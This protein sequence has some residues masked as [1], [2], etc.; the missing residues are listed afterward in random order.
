MIVRSLDDIQGTDRD[1]DTPN[2]VSKRLLLAKDGTAFS[3]HDTVIRAGTETYMWYAHHVE[4]V[5]CVGGEGE[6]ET[7]NDG[8]VYKI[9]DGAMYTLDQN[10]KHI[11]RARTEM[12]MVCVFT[13]PLTGREVHD[14]NGIYPLVKEP[15]APDGV[16]T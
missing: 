14:E 2:W 8:K 15:A 6:V 7:V 16:A 9:A 4:A 13:P 1:V 5:Y 10:E 12:R 11:L 3:L